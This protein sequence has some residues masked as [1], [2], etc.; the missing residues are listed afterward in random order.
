MIV[1]REGVVDF[2]FLE[3]VFAPELLET[4]FFPEGEVFFVEVFFLVVFFAA[5]WVGF[6]VRDYSSSS[7][8]PMLW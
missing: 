7:S 5:F 1:E 4:S 6:F 2:D 8:L 3:E